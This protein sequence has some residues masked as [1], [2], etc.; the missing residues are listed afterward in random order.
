MKRF[1]CVVLAVALCFGL[2]GC[3][4]EYRDVDTTRNI[5]ENKT[6]ASVENEVSGPK[7]INPLINPMNEIN[8]LDIAI[9]NI[10]IFCS[11]AK[12]YSGNFYKNILVINDTDKSDTIVINGE[13]T[14]GM[15][16]GVDGDIS[17]ILEHCTKYEKFVKDITVVATQ[18]GVDKYGNEIKTIKLMASFKMSEL[19][20]VKWDTFHYLQLHNLAESYELY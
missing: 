17:K 8:T 11:D 7:L 13:L 10:G 20:K 19:L 6:S 15:I 16:S 1:V 5:A 12:K 18:K 3:S 14:M 2:V 9:I 4:K